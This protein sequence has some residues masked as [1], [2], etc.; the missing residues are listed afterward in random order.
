MLPESLDADEDT[1][2]IIIR[3]CLTINRDV[4][5]ARSFAVVGS[6]NTWDNHHG[7]S[8]RRRETTDNPAIVSIPS[9][10]L[11]PKRGLNTE[12]LFCTQ[13]KAK[14]KHNG[15]LVLAS[16]RGYLA[17]V[18]IIAKTPPDASVGPHIRLPYK[19]SLRRFMP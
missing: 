18:G 12:H 16:A 8:C 10:S 13:A 17:D 2:R 11:P 7:C 3:S 4:K 14:K 5:V 15:L 9:K 6:H 1:S 19:P